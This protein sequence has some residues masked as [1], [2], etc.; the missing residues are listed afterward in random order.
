MIV[1]RLYA[2][3]I[4]VL[5]ATT[6]VAAYAGDDVESLFAD[7]QRY[8]SQKQWS[9]AL[10][11]YEKILHDQPDNA[12]ALYRRGLVL[13]SLG[14]ND[15]A[16]KSFQDALRRDPNLTE[17]SEALE[18]HYVTKGYAARAANRHDEAIAAFRE[19][20][21][22]NPKG[23]TSRL[24]LG[25]ELETRGDLNGAAAEYAAVV[26][27][28]PDDATAHARFAA[29]SAKQGNNERAAKQYEEVVRLTPR[30]PEAHRGLALAYEALGRHDDALA[31]TEQAIRTYM[32]KGLE[33][34]AIEM[35]QLERKLMA[36]G[37]KL[38]PTPRPSP[39]KK[40]D[41]SDDD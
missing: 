2:L 24:E 30:D 23:V 13:D 12:L 33:D 18:G 28:H 32:L 19:G 25:Q 16:I 4:A 38:H 5:V 21:T 20:V 27:T 3:V 10:S 39:R 14:A 36:A 31:E 15:M 26:R 40:T 9:M 1:R 35:T 29:V 17:A 7:A 34:K 41:A 37:A 8:E 22:V 11:M 6:S